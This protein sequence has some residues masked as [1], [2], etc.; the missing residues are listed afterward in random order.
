MYLLI[1]ITLTLGEAKGLIFNVY[2]YTQSY[3][4]SNLPPF[5]SAGKREEKKN[6]RSSV[7]VANGSPLCNSH[8]HFSLGF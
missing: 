4:E 3:K 2:Y 5:S 7:V 8:C 6:H 1:S